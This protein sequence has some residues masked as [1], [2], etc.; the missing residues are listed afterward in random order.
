MM[1]FELYN[2][3]KLFFSNGGDCNYLRVFS[4]LKHEE[5]NVHKVSGEKAFSLL[6]AHRQASKLRYFSGREVELVLRVLARNKHKEINFI[7]GSDNEL[8]IIF[9]FNESFSDCL[10]FLSFVPHKKS[11]AEVDEEK[12]ILSLTDNN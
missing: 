6:R 11:K 10:G 9:Y 2:N 4:K 8:A 7:A 12:K 5:Y 1:E 3:I